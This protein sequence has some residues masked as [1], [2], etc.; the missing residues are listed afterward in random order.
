MH[1]QQLAQPLWNSVEQNTIKH[2]QT[3]V[4]YSYSDRARNVHR[5]VSDVAQATQRHQASL[6]VG[7]RRCTSEQTKHKYFSLK[8]KLL[9]THA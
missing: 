3:P 1:Q 4:C 8:Q 2:R 7:K 6:I 5:I 9:E